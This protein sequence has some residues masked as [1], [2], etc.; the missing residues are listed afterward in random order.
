M[1]NKIFNIIEFDG[2]R[3]NK[4]A[5]AYSYFMIVCIVV[6]LIP[7]TFKE[8]TPLFNL[9]E[10]VT[11]GVF[12]IDYSLRWFTADLRLDKGIKSFVIYPF[13]LVAVIDLLSILPA[14]TTLSR[15]FKSF[16]LLRL[17]K[18]LRVFKAFK[19]SSNVKRL[20]KVFR[21]EKNNLMTVLFLSLSY[22]VITALAIFSIEPETF[23]TF[24]EALYWA[25]VSLTTVGYGD[26]FP[27]TVGGRTISMIS[28]L[29]GIAI[30]AI[31]SGIITAGYLDE[32]Q[33]DQ[34]DT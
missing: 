28:S 21:K 4:V 9:I 5:D 18:V 33:K 20:V 1:R 16:R 7:L 24:F 27:V 13:T 17:M 34:S 2:E 12:I 19:Y 26:I 22:I 8:T 30:I 32:I 31:P 3:K 6:S 29:F 25:T 23:D 14:F 11:V 10:R 15:V